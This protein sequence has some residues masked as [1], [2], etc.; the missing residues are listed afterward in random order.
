MWLTK[1][2]IYLGIILSAVVLGAVW[3]KRLGTP[4]KIILVLVTIT[5]IS[6]SV[7]VAMA[8][9]G[10]NFAVYHIFNV[11]EALLWGAFYL[12]LFS[13]KPVK[14]IV[15]GLCLAVVLFMIT[16]SLCIQL[17]NLEANNYSVT[18]E[19]LMLLIF[20]LNFFREMMHRP[21]TENLFR[22]PYFWL[23]CAVLFFYTI[24][25][26]FWTSYN[27]LGKYNQ[28]LMRAGFELLFYSNYIFYATIA[29]CFLLEAKNNQFSTRLPN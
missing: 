15:V 9:Q 7:A 8:Y 19:S 29:M 17:Y 21:S 18:G 16:N 11:V 3:A 13:S 10:N 28:S 20:S 26:L 22:F 1:R 24:N 4:M 6:E 14:R 2:L 25:I 23:N 5:L 27:L 12:C